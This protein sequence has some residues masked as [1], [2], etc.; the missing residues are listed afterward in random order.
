MSLIDE[1]SNRLRVAGTVVIDVETTGLDW[2]NNRICGYVL[3]FGPRHDDTFYIPVG[4][5]SGPNYDPVTVRNMI[6]SHQTRPRRWI[7]HNLAF[8]L[9]FLT[10]AG[11]D[12]VGMFED[13]MINAALLDEFRKSF[14]L[15]SCAEEAHVQAKLS[16][17]IKSHIEAY[18][19]RSFGKNYM[20][21]FW[22][23]PADDP[24]AVDYATGDGTTTWQLWD[25]QQGRIN[26]QNLHMVHNVE[27]RLIP[28]LNRM[29]MRGIKV[30]ADRLAR[31]RDVTQ[32][33]LDKA[34][35]DLGEGVNVNSNAQIRKL[36][37]DAGITDWPKTEAGGPSF[38]EDF[39]KSTDVGK[40]VIAVR[41]SLRMMDAFII[42]MMDRH[43]HKG[44][45]HAT[46]NQLRGD[47]FGTVTGRL[48]SSNP[49]LQQVPKRDAEAG[50]PF[51][52]IF[53]PDEGMIWGSADYSQCEPR[54]LAHYSKCKVLTEGYTQTPSVDAHTAVANAAGIDRQ[55]GKRLNQAL[56]TGAGV[57]K[58]AS[59]LGKP[60]DE[61][62]KIVNQYFDAMPEIRALQA[63][64]SNI[65]KNRRYVRS[66]LWRRSRLEAPGKEY[67]AVNRLL[68]CSNADMIKLSMVKLDEMHRSVGGI[69][70]LN[71]VHD[72][73]DFQYMPDRRDAYEESLRIMCDFPE[74]SIPIE[75]DEDSGPDWAWASYGEK[76]WK[77][78]MTDRGMLDTSDIDDQ[79]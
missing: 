4:H 69:D 24:M 74:I 41:K 47:Q 68:Q 59:M 11:I 67:K 29:T 17:E 71:N 42:P 12:L 61:A 48:S 8:D 72:S 18:F 3:T 31:F 66:I 21:E 19:G 53:V 44:R 1:V 37:E 36:H 28:V 22:R 34:R 49:N 43:L 55:S 57:K 62:M 50:I 40:K 73:I 63:E 26:D 15:Q 13:T 60:M 23:L 76:D 33:A 52:S 32:A 30:D 64:A 27:C 10:A 16:D 25:F 46:F 75:V 39:L 6:V 9:G 35:K 45:V 20:G 5:E 70:M 65:M 77:R 79:A 7:G 78:V 51:R 54:L 58:A 56:L 14:S 38:T 2:R